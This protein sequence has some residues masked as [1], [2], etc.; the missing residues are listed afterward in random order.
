MISCELLAPPTGMATAAE[1]TA[2][3]SLVAYDE[4]EEDEEDDGTRSSDE[5]LLVP[6][7]RT[8]VEKTQEGER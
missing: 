1:A 4:E 6:R 3:A 5:E 7:K 8:R 2:T